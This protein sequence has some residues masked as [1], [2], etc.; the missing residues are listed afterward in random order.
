MRTLTYQNIGRETMQFYG[1][2]TSIRSIGKETIYFYGKLT[3]NQI[4]GKKTM[5]LLWE[6]NF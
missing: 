6:I 5:Q 2:L 3:S 1:K 4:I